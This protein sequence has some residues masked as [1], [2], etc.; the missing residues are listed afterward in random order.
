[1]RL[2]LVACA[3]CGSDD[4]RIPGA[5]DGVLVGLGQDLGTMA[6]RACGHVAVPLEF[7]SEAARLAFVRVRAR[8]GP[9]TPPA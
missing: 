4:L 9:P 2:R 5:G 6:C 7:A 1:V 8:R 3:R